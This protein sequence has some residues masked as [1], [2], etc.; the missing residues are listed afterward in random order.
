[1]EV[2]P[3][4]RS[5]VPYTM[6]LPPIPEMILALS[7]KTLHVTLTVI[8]S[9]IQNRSITLIQMEYIRKCLSLSI[10]V[11]IFWL[12]VIFDEDLL[13]VSNVDSYLPQD[14][15]KND[16]Q[17]KISSFVVLYDKFYSPNMKKHSKI[18]TDHIDVK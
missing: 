3:F 11:W 13:S 6:R 14:I 4:R 17:Y 1:V 15:W 9:S 8:I 2:T 16:M 18:K 10:D 7:D 5:I 12:I